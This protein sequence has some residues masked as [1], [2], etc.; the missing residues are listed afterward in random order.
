MVAF[1]LGNEAYL[2]LLHQAGR[3]WP[4]VNDAS[5]VADAEASCNDL[6]TP[7]C[8][9]GGASLEKHSLTAFRSDLVEI[10]SGEYVC[11]RYEQQATTNRTFPDGGLPGLGVQQ[12]S[13]GPSGS[14]HREARFVQ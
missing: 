10:Y 8:F 6:P 11:P 4:Q 9:T 13:A 7:E 1:P 12:N 3:H 2:A 14:S 5:G